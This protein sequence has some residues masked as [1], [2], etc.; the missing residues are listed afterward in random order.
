MCHNARPSMLPPGE[1][2]T[3][4]LTVRQKLQ[5][6]IGCLPLILYC[7]AA[8]VYG[9]ATALDMTEPLTLA[10]AGGGL[11]FFGFLARTWLRDLVFGAALVREATLTELF[12]AGGTPCATFAQI[13]TFS[14]NDRKVHATATTGPRYRIVY[15]PASRLIWTLERVQR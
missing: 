11:L 10:W 13:G 7:I 2:S 5:L 4:P 8:L 3:V 12:F 1:T 6:A 15:S 14:V 9:Y